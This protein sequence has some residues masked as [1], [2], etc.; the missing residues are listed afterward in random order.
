M[1]AQVLRTTPFLTAKPQ[2]VR[3]PHLL[4]CVLDVAVHLLPCRPGRLQPVIK[5]LAQHIHGDHKLGT[6]QASSSSAVQ[7]LRPNQKQG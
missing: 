4:Q 3:Q 1:T 2:T 6:W 5:L 7:S